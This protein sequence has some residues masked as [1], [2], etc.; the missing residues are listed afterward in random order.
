VV[1][2]DTAMDGSARGTEIDFDNISTYSVPSSKKFH[3]AGTCG[4][5]EALGW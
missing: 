5:L 3:D 1:C 4:W 2:D